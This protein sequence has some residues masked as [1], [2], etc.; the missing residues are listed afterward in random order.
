MAVKCHCNPSNN[1]SKKYKL[2]SSLL[3]SNTQKGRKQS[4]YKPKRW[5]EGEKANTVPYIT[6]KAKRFGSYFLAECFLIISAKA[7]ATSRQK[8]QTLVHKDSP[9]VNMC[10]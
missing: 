5:Q 8:K 9:Q 3:V 2:N 7:K 10:S 1:H 4:D 6:F